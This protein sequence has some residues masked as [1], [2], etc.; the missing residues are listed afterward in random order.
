MYVSALAALT[1]LRELGGQGMLLVTTK[2]FLPIKEV[3]FWMK[4]AKW[5]KNNRGDFTLQANIFLDIQYKYS[6][7]VSAYSLRAGA[8]LLDNLHCPIYLFLLQTN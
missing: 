3:H 1:I 2:R 7:F 4:F 6:G 5:G 8:V